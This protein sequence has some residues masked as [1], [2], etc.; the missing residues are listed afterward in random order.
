MFPLIKEHHG[1][2]KNL[3]IFIVTNMQYDKELVYIIEPQCKTLRKKEQIQDY[4]KENTAG[5]YNL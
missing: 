5:T 3:E 1:E 2:E 4:F